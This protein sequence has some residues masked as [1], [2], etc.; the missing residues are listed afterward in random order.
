MQTPANTI[1]LTGDLGGEKVAMTF[2]E[3]SLAHL[4]SLFIDM[5]SDREL[6]AIREYSTNALDAHVQ[7]GNTAP[8]EVFT[9]SAL[10]PYFRVVDHGVG[11]S[12]DDIKDMYSKY[13]AS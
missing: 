4:Q 1:S 3:K 5:Y 6:A 11:L 9:P 8:I 12:I 13:G 2:D 10:S 7:A